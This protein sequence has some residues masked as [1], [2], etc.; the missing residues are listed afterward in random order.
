MNNTTVKKNDGIINNCK[1][2]ENIIPM[3]N[4]TA[5]AVTKSKKVQAT[6]LSLKPDVRQRLIDLSDACNMSK[7]EFTSRLI[8]DSDSRIVSFP[9]GKEILTDIARCYQILS[10]ITDNMDD[11]NI[12]HDKLDNVIKAL[13]NAAFS[14][15]CLCNKMDALLPGEEVTD[16]DN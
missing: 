10:D 5:P 11:N 13:N 4:T 1:I 16:D 3:D 9:E 7:T 12:L 6:S 8:M 14:M 15:S 2:Q